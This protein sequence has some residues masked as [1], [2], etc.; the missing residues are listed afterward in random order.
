MPSGRTD[1]PP[2]A[3]TVAWFRQEKRISTG[4]LHV[5][6]EADPSTASRLYKG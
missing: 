1:L 2:H 5:A 4:A 6:W 3:E